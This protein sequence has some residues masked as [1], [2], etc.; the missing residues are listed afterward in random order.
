MVA[1]KIP[2]KTSTPTRGK[3]GGT[4]KSAPLKAP[5]EPTVQA[6]AE[7]APSVSKAVEAA[8]PKPVLEAAPVAIPE[9]APQPAPAPEPVAAVAAEPVLE[10]TP[11]PEPEELEEIIDE[12]VEQLATLAEQVIHE[13]EAIAGEAAHNFQVAMKAATGAQGVIP[14]LNG[15]NSYLYRSVQINARFMEQFTAIRS[16]IDLVNLQVHFLEE[17]RVAM[18][19]F[20]QQWTMKKSAS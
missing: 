19:E 11:E 17:H 1:S 20:T 4:A 8:E 14:T 2:N 18:L 3:L 16:P 12:G 6:A 10:A 15:I 5:A 7:A 9:P 13:A